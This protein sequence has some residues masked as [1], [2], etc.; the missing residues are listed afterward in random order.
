[1][2][3][4]QV[5]GETK[6]ATSRQAG[7]SLVELMIALVIGLI[8]V[9]GAGQLFLTGIQ[10]FRQVELLGNKQAALT[11]A[12]DTLIRDIRRG[13]NDKIDWNDPVLSVE[14]KDQSGMD[15]CPG[16]VVTREYSVSEN[17]VS[18][19]EGWS[20]MMRQDCNDG[21]GWS[22]AEPL[23]T[24]LAP[25]AAKGLNVDATEK[26]DGIYIIRLCLIRE[27]GDVACGDTIDFHAVNRTAALSN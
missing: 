9:L 11:F 1:M 16:E 26:A 13:N 27:P 10:S 5:E 7:F 20:L 18:N 23:V 8:I 14:F 17:S 6:M 24:G 21:S 2:T 25:P 19:T 12:A 15:G 3:I 22:Q 4:S